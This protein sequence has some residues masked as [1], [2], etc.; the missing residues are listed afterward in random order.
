MVKKTRVLRLVF[1]V[2]ESPSLSSDLEPRRVFRQAHRVF[3]A[4]Q[5]QSR[6]LQG[7]RFADAR[8]AVARSVNRLPK[9]VQPWPRGAGGNQKKK[10]HTHI[11][12]KA[13]VGG[14]CEYPPTT[15]RGEGV[16]A[17]RTRLPAVD[18]GRPERLQP[19]GAV[20]CFERR[21]LPR[22]PRTRHVTE[23]FDQKGA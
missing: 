7:A 23:P 15:R 20:D 19:R 6:A 14:T 18:G 8:V 2:D 13:A 12:Y 5:N 22:R 10:T 21:A 9:Y 3:L 4:V 16:A 17:L 1:Y 11:R